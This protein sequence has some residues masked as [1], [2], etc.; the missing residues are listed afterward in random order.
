MTADIEATI[1]LVLDAVERAMRGEDTDALAR[2]ID[3]NGNLGLCYEHRR[4]AHRLAFIA[5]AA[6]ARPL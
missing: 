1:N 2:A 5:R 6:G 3:L 4:L